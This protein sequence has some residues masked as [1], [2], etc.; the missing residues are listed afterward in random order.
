M[1]FSIIGL[2]N[3]QSGV[4]LRISIRNASALNANCLFYSSENIN[5]DK[6]QDDTKQ[7]KNLPVFKVDNLLNQIPF[8]TE[9]V[10]VELDKESENLEDFIHPENAFYIFGNEITGISDDLKNIKSKKNSY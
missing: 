4:N 10:I 9:L 6:R 5:L 2:E 3:I 1:G 7:Y 8:G